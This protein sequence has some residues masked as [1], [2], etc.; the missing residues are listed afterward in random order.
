MLAMSLGDSELGNSVTVTVGM[1]CEG[2]TSQRLQDRIKQHIPKS[3]SNAA[4]SQIR[5]QLS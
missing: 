5:I 2:R 3:I 4:C 1:Q